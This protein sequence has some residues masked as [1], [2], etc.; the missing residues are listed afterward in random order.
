MQK[1]NKMRT[2]L[3][4]KP[5][6]LAV[7]LLTRLP[8]TAITQ[9]RDA[10]IGQSA[11]Y[12]PLVGLLIGLLLFLSILLFSHADAMPL[13]AMMIMQWAM[14][15]GGLHLDG[16]A[17]SADGWLGGAGSRDKTLQIMKDPLVGS[18]GVVAIVCVLL[19]KFAALGALLQQKMGYLVIF[20]PV[21]AR[22]M[23]L[24]LFLTTPYV[25]D[26]G[27]ASKITKHLPRK[28]AA[29]VVAFCLLAG[30]IIAFW[31]MLFMLAGFWLLRRL[32]LKRL[33][34][35]TGDTT[36]ATVE[37][38]EMLILLGSALLYQVAA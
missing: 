28:Q 16:L 2:P 7:S 24:L 3:R 37:I 20:T 23:V 36:G 19:V 9:V 11:L 18:A 6:L 27:M 13:A 26:H 21:L 10:D 29:W 4:L 35:C 38:S 8:V 17:D 31:G 22:S 1:Q 15:T 25:S 5:F 33:G 34:G 14:I 12:Y 32:M 30:L